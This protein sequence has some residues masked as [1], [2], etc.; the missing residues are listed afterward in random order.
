VYCFGIFDLSEFFV[1]FVVC[2]GRKMNA[3]LEKAIQ[4]AMSELDAKSSTT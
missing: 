4:E 1:L 2:R 3:Q